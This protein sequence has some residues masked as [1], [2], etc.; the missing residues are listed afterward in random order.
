M[1]GIERLSIDQLLSEVSE[2]EALG[3]SAIALFPV[4]S[5]EKNHWKPKN[6]T[7]QMALCKEPSVN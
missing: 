3:I 7:I 6:R 5:D 4:I 2:I 1:P